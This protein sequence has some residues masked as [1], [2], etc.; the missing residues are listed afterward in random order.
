MVDFDFIDWDD[1]DDPRG[2]VRHVAENGVSAEEVEEVLE[3]PDATDGV[4]RSRVTGRQRSK[5]KRARVMPGAPPSRS[6]ARTR[7]PP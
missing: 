6:S 1:E 4:S 5:L 7:I 2:N 3:S